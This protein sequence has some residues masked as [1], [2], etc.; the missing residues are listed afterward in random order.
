[1]TYRPRLLTLAD[2]GPE[3]VVPLAP[4]GVPVPKFKRTGPPVDV[5]ALGL[6]DV[7]T[8]AV[9]EVADL[10]VVKSLTEQSDVWASVPASPK[11]E[12]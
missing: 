8:G 9:V 3:V 5:P 10:A 4:Q 12:K 7:E 2:R 1:M 11:K 6:V